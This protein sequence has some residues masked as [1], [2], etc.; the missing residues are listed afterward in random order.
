MS[1]QI[2]KNDEL[3]ALWQREQQ[4]N[5]EKLYFGGALT[6]S[7]ER[8]KKMIKEG[9]YKL[10]VVMFPNDFRTD[11]NNQPAFRLKE[12]TPQSTN[13]SFQKV[14]ETVVEEKGE[15]K[16]VELEEAEDLL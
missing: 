12:A 10:S 15:V 4:N 3:G 6:L 9:D 8:V 1:E 14:A 11:T 7:E 5:P 13:R 2:K 16:G